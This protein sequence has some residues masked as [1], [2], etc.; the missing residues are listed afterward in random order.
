MAEQSIEDELN[1][2]EEAIRKLKN[3]YDMFFAGLRKLP[4][5]EDR[6]RLDEAMREMQRGRLRDNASRFRFATL[7]SRYQQY[8]E[9][10]A[11]KMRER[12]EGPMDY[13]RR[14]AA[15]T[16]GGQ[17]APPPAPPAQ[18]RRTETSPA[19]DSYVRVSQSANGDAVKAI[20]QQIA[21]ANRKLGKATTLTVEQLASMVEK[22]S[23]ELRSRYNVDSVGFRVELVEGKVK[24]KAKPL[25]DR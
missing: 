23:A 6:K 2:I 22:Q 4:P 11:R 8:Q 14:V 5:S 7:L 17:Q 15:L 1:R 9:L 13:R 12:E 10:W 20:H 19:S 18:N 3:M 24:L 16:N 21:E 25:Q